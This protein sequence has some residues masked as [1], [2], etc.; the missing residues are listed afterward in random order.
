MNAFAKILWLALCLMTLSCAG[1]PPR[2]LPEQDPPMIACGERKPADPPPPAPSGTD[3]RVWAKAFVKALAW[4]TQHADLRAD[5][6][7]CLD[8]A[9][10][11]GDIR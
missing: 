3:W 8:R 10:A 6:A 7:D 9:R 2:P 4:G 1:R 5:T 11:A